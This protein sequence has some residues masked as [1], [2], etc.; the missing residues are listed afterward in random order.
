MKVTLEY[1]QAIWLEP[2]NS[3]SSHEVKLVYNEADNTTD[4]VVTAMHMDGS[5]ATPV[6]VPSKN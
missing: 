2:P 3:E 4:L 6:V 5:P 1:D